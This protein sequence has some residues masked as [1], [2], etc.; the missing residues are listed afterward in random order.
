MLE[1]DLGKWSGA[2]ENLEL[3]GK[4]SQVARTRK[5]TRSEDKETVP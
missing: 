4:V 2:S 1:P 3:C 5:Y